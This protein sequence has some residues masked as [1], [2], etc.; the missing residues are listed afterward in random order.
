MVR[1]L[2]NKRSTMIYLADKHRKAKLSAAKRHNKT[3]STQRLGK[4]RLKSLGKWSRECI[5]LAFKM[6]IRNNENN[7]MKMSEIL[8]THVL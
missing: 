1:F 7:W 4:R 8:L 2:V 5:P 3:M 6:I